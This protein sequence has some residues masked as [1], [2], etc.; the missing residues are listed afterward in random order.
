[1]NRRVPLPLLGIVLTLLF[2]PLHGCNG[3]SARDFW[4]DVLRKCA[5]SD[6]TKSNFLYFGPS[7][8]YGPGSILE[9]LPDN[10]YQ[11]RWTT[12]S[13]G[14]QAGY[15][16]ENP[17]ASCKGTKKTTSSMNASLALTSDFAPVSG[18]LG[19]DFKNAKTITAS[20]D[21]WQKVDL[22]TG[23]F[24]EYINSPMASPKVKTDLGRP[25]R[26]II[27]VAYKVKGLVAT[28]EFS[29]TV[30]ASLK[31]KYSG[32][33]ASLQGAQASVGFTGT[34]TDDRTLE[35]RSASEFYIA[36]TL[37]PVTPTGEVGVAAVP[38]FNLGKEVDNL[39]GAKAVPAP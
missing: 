19:G 25:N 12:T 13:I 21:L 27:G 35:L 29:R 5:E 7:N 32:Q 4:D 10:N 16:H 17:P 39:R 6:L 8:D 36:G 1:M 20:V 22:V 37:I 9:R 28:I 24:G 31:A 18:D 30:D 34:W 26:F 38:S 3:G 15:I 2:V 33:I 23:P 11:P 14:G